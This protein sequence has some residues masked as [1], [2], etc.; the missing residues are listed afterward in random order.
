LRPRSRGRISLRSTDPLV[1]PSIEAGYLTDSSDRALALELLK[2]M[3]EL[4]ATDPLARFIE[5]PHD[6]PGGQASD[7]E[8]MDWIERKALSIYHPAGTCA[9]GPDADGGA[10]VD[11]RLRVHGIDSLRVVDASVM[12][13]IV[14]GNTNAPSVM[15]GE[16]A[17]AM[18]RE[19]WAH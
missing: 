2:K 12:P 1:A 19:D 6:Q 13:T 17:A 16:H 15:I 11:A 9:M 5:S 10:V 4:A 3:R 8:M 18:V 7:A 14:S